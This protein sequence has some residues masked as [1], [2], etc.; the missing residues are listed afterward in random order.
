MH[1]QSVIIDSKHHNCLASAAKVCL[2]VPA[3]HLSEAMPLP[4][5][6]QHSSPASAAHKVL[7]NGDCNI[8]SLYVYLASTVHQV[9]SYMTD[10][11]CCF[12]SVPAYPARPM[13]PLNRLSV[14]AT[15]R[16]CPLTLLLLMCI[17]QQGETTSCGRDVE[18]S[19]SIPEKPASATGCSRFWAARAQGVC[20]EVRHA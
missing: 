19:C 6:G 11:A 7:T 9:T 18:S 1:P 3:T 2:S 16:T 5:L 15:L 17:R 10:C 14:I 13:Q 12:S 20:R 8:A 4:A